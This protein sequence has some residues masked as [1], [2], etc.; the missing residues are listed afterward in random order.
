MLN[1][2]DRHSSLTI[3]NISS[4]KSHW[5]NRKIENTARL[6]GFRQQLEALV[7]V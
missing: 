2:G 3:L 1:K 4:I 7:N 6:Y 5:K